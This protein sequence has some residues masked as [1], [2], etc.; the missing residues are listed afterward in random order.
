MLENAEIELMQADEQD[1]K[2]AFEAIDRRCSQERTLMDQ[3]WQLVSAVWIELHRRETE[4]RK[5]MA[6]TESEQRHCEQLKAERNSEAAERNK[7]D[8]IEQE[9]RSFEMNLNEEQKCK[10]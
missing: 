8:L 7:M 3:E 1:V 6:T 5:E 9:S 2:A 10:L 4:E